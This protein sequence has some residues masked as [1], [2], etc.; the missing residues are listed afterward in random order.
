[1]T[2]V[3]MLAC[4][5]T[6]T[7]L[8]SVD[9]AAHSLLAE[10]PA[11]AT[12]LAS[13]ELAETLQSPLLEGWR[14]R[15]A[16]EIERLDTQWQ[17]RFGATL[18]GTDRALL[19]CN[20]SGCSWHLQGD[21]SALD[22]GAVGAQLARPE[23][24]VN[25]VRRVQRQDALLF[26]SQDGTP[27]RL[28]R[29]AADRLLLG[30]GPAVKAMASATTGLGVTGLEGA[31]PQGDVWVVARDP[32]Q[33]REQVLGYLAWRDTDDARDG[34]ARVE[35]LWADRPELVDDIELIALS[36][37]LEEPSRVA[38]RASCW[39]V[40]GAERVFGFLEPLLAAQRLESALDPRARELLGHVELVREGR[41]VELRTQDRFGIL[42]F[43]LSVAG[44][45]L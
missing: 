19:G 40:E 45:S 23:A 36:L 25:G 24:G 2:L 17:G 30:H 14:A 22:L 9:P 44:S 38:V 33:L 1:M 21:Y 41:R 32:E 8:P 26:R 42:E 18:N 27:L 39:D 28:Q 5:S 34:T 6:P 16:L 43:L 4:G 31:I 37:S 10:A 35:A 7:L 12:L 15:H 3:L 13:L 29:V 20:Q 11:E